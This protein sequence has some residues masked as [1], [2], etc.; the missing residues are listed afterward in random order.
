[1]TGSVKMFALRMLPNRCLFSVA[2]VQCGCLGT[3]KR[4][5]AALSTPGVV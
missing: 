4:E 5:A 1:M 3:C 2:Y